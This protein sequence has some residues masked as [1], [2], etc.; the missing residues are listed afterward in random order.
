MTCYRKESLTIVIVYYS[1]YYVSRACY[2]TVLWI[3]GK[4]NHLFALC[5]SFCSSAIPGKEKQDWI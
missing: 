2:G 1:S 3:R 4:S 5:R